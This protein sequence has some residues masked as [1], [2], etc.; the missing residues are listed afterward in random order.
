[1]ADEITDE[2]KAY[3]TSEGAKIS[4]MAR[5]PLSRLSIR[6]TRPSSLLMF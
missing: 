3:L 1:V 6:L 2:A 5:K 4:S